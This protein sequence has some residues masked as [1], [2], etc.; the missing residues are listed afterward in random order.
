MT[1]I[2]GEKPQESSPSGAPAKKPLPFKR[3]V[4]RGDVL[5]MVAK[6]D[7]D[8]AKLEQ[9]TQPH[10]APACKTSPLATDPGGVKKR[11]TPPTPRGPQA[12]TEDAASKSE[13]TQTGGLG[14][15]ATVLLTKGGKDQGITGQR[16]EV[17]QA[18]ELKEGEPQGKEGPGEAGRPGTVEKRGG[19]PPNKMA[20]GNLSKDAGGE[21]KLAGAQIQV[22][23]WGGFLGRRSRLDGPQ[24]TDKE[25]MLPSKAEKTDKPQIKA[26]KM[27]KVQGEVGK[28]K[29]APRV[30]EKADGSQS[31]SQEAGEAGGETEKG[32]EAS[33]EVDACRETPAAAEKEGQPDGRGQQAEEPCARLDDKAKAL[34]TELEGPR[35]P[36]LE[37]HAGRPQ[38]QETRE[39]PAPQ[40][41]GKGGQSG[42]SDQ[43]RGL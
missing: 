22:K 8:S 12:S 28:V 20:K 39:G 7:P 2:N 3:G 33:K 34:V 43:V 1:T 36:A 40:E 15:P 23:K 32:R 31:E 5:L 25:G 21:G 4:R 42:D 35:P 16:G 9:R 11:E 24:K 18:K 30:M 17:P 19:D 38:T 6:L 41:E 10:D 29:E 26:E 13:K 27:D 37:S 14:N